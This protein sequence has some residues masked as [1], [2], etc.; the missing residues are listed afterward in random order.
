[1]SFRHSR[2]FKDYLDCSC[3]YCQKE[4]SKKN[5]VESRL[6]EAEMVEKEE[7]LDE[8]EAQEIVKARREIFNGE[9]LKKS[10]GPG[11][12]ELGL[13]KL[14]QIYD[15]NLSNPSLSKLITRCWS[16][17]QDWRKEQ[18]KQDKLKFKKIEKSMK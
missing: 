2:F 4:V 13:R 7:T 3:E 6:K 11:Y 18:E 5:L 1:M 9:K 12:N 14:R 8:A 10:E 15:P 17:V 16:N